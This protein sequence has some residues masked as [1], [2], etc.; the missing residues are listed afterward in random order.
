MK[1]IENRSDVSLL[2]NTFYNTIRE[3]ALLGPIFNSF[4]SKEQWPPHLDKLTDF[5]MT[6]LFGIPC[7]KG[8]P[9]AAHFKV[10]KNLK[11]GMSQDHFQHWLSLWF[12]TID[13]LFMGHLAERAKNAATMMAKGQLNIVKQNRDS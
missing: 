7:F 8:S 11:Q 13:S 9:T 3:D 2:V 10:D 5:W 12:A 4:L 1:E 6:N